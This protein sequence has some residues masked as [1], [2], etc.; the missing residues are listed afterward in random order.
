L[1]DGKKEVRMHQ[2]GRNVTIQGSV[3]SEGLAEG[4]A[5]VYQD[6][7][8]KDP[9][10]SDIPKDSVMAETTR[11]CDTMEVVR[12]DLIQASKRVD[13]ALGS[14]MGDIFRAHQEMLK[15][16][17]LREEILAEI[18][19]ESVKAEFAL[20]CVLGRWEKKFR[21]M[22][23]ASL[24]L[25]AD[26][27]RDLGRRLLRSLA[28][29]QT[30]SLEMM[31]EG[32][33]LVAKRLL[34][35]D[36]TFFARR[37]A[38]GIVVEKGGPASHCALL[39]RQ[40]G[41]PGIA[42]TSG[43]LEQVATGD[44]LLL[45]GQS[46]CITISPD[47]KQREQFLKRMNA[48]QSK[49]S[50]SRCNRH[51]PAVTRDGMTIP[52]MANIGNHHDAK[53]A[54]EN[55]ADGIGLLRIE[56][57]FLSRSMLPSEK[58]LTDALGHAITPFKTKPV[59]VRLLDIGGDKQLPYL[60]AVNESNPLLG[61]RGVR[62][63]LEFPKLLEVQLRALLDLSR[64]FDI[65]ILVPMVT[66]TED[67]LQIRAALERQAEALGCSTLPPL[68]AMI[69]TP[70]SAL[71]T[72]ELAEV[73]DFFNIGSNDLTQYTMAAGR[74][75]PAVH[76]YFQDQHPAILRLL[77]LV[78]REN[79][80]LQVGLC[81]ELAGKIPAIPSILQSGVRMLSVAP[82]LVSQVKEAI[83]KTWI[84]PDPKTRRSTEEKIPLR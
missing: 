73:S 65:R 33:I 66:V 8:E 26:D 78:G 45:D 42:Q 54:A 61:R 57:F 37:F 58:E 83:R 74:E 10:T 5:Y 13:E 7:F 32:S 1:P 53:A 44:H 72:G 68:G 31:P 6:I 40:F 81:G 14:G 75:D 30:H 25:R 27:I 52:V 17:Y 49:V 16:A 4:P 35:S 22:Q 19:R 62:I 77:E 84:F 76:A 43:L 59:T 34:P 67:V 82:P 36:T 47:K 56:V 11:L 20:Q 38:A 63:L 28:G 69:E 60:P 48:Y 24:K 2:D 79:A 80:G 51:Q 21:S 23:D 70:A 15:D 46:G 12:Q 41:I 18:K 71:C 29:G 9:G 3:I 64:D 39:T 55:G 50:R